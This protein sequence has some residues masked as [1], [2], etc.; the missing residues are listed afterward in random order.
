MNAVRVA[1]ILLGALCATRFASAAPP[2]ARPNV[3]VVIA[4][5][6]GYSDPGCYGGEIPTPNL[7]AL[8]AGGLR[9]THFYNTARCWPS[10]AALLTGYYAQQVRR[11]QVPGV[12]S[13][14]GGVRPA[15][16]GL[17]PERLRPLGYRSFFSGKWHV[18]GRPNAGGFDRSYFL[19]DLGRYFNP[20]VHFEDETKLPPPAPNSGW[21]ATVAIADYAIKFLREHAAAHADRPFFLYLAFNAPHFPLQAPAEDVARHRDA[22]ARGWDAVRKERAERQRKAGIFDGALPEIERDVGP[23]YRFPDAIK[24]L[25]PGELDRA[26]AWTELTDAQRAFQAAK[27]AIH[28]A[29][30][31]R[32]DRELGRVLAQLRAMKALDDTLILFLSDN[33]ASAE[34]MIRDDG[35]DPAA[36]PGSAATHLCL[37]PGWSAAAN[38]P[39]RRHKTWVHEGGICTPFIVHWPRGIA[40]RGELR[41]NPGHVIDIAPTVLEIAGG[42]FTAAAGAPAPPGRSLVPA[43]TRDGV[44]PHDYLW[45]LHEGNRA[46]RVGDWK[47]V[48][49]KGGGWE[50]YDL[51]ADR[52]ETRDLASAHPDRVAAMEREWTRRMEEFSATARQD[53]PAAVEK[54]KKKADE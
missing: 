44:A 31:D 16:A 39:F 12:P 49:L 2:P 5:D 7:D 51:A 24:K 54:K 23:P 46:I 30:V 29:M 19:S 33:G 50:L 13:G 11:D 8:A 53:A 26:P 42:R 35:H 28:A 18:D 47:A 25:G 15:W 1:I 41:R 20:R 10:R 22:Y 36:P 37:G 45:W 34:I 52:A 6:M 32:M 43:F 48:A 4:D 21:Y 17:L 14:G 27:M 3:V 9:F 40:A 38:T